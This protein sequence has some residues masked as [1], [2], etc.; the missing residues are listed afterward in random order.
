MLL[1]DRRDAGQQLAAKLLRFKDQRPVILALPRG[2]VPV[3]FEIAA[4]L[5]APLDVV[6]VRK[7]GHPRSRELAVGAIAEGETLETFIDESAVA[8]LGVPQR[9]LEAEIA[10]QTRE[11]AHRRLLYFKGRRPVDIRQR[12]ALVVDD[13]I[14]TGATMRAALRAVRRRAPARLVLA[15]PVAP[16]STLDALRPEVDE[17]VCLSAPDDFG[18]VGFFYD[19]FQPVDDTV[20]IDLLERAA[21]ATA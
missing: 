4:R 2:G 5:D 17:I 7:I 11:I 8:E 19:D 9:Y 6:L 1:A 15:V 3:G 10:R 13:G 18:A 20:V 14:A 21:A 12:T 16:A